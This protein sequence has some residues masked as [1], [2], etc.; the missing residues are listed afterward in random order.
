MFRS[1]NE[2]TVRSILQN[3]EDSKER[4][5]ALQPVQELVTDVP[6]VDFGMK[7][8]TKNL[9][10]PQVT[11]EP[12]AESTLSTLLH[13]SELAELS[14]YIIL[15]SFEACTVFTHMVDFIAN[16]SKSYDICPESYSVKGYAFQDAKQVGFQFQ[17]FQFEDKLGISQTR[18]D[19]CSFL[20]NGL[21]TDL[22]RELLYQ[23]DLM[24]D[25]ESESDYS[26]SEDEDDAAFSLFNSPYLDFTQDVEYLARLIDDIV[27]CQCDEHATMLLA[28]NI[29]NPNNYELMQPF[30]QT[31]VNN[32]ITRLASYDATLP[33][34]RSAA[35]LINTLVSRELNI[36]LTANQFKV[37]ATT[38]ANW[39]TGVKETTNFVTLSEEIGIF[40]SAVLVE[41]WNMCQQ[42]I[43][44]EMVNFFKRIEDQVAQTQ[45]DSIRVNFDNFIDY[46]TEVGTA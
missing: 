34:V 6:T 32:C 14:V 46:Q 22:K 33:V 4:S 18:M 2:N 41:I 26:D 19:G 12:A 38:A 10:E 29:D 42:Q 43:T 31:I 44:Q 16:A 15:G 23:L 39:S 25:D 40:L 1:L 35:K 11:F 13:V 27:N 21:F 36:S 9:Y 28:H 20:L 3:K 7:E 8:A 17:L 5:R 30:A 37:I 24:D 45:Y